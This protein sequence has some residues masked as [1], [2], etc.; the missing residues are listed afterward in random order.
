MAVEE[1]EVVAVI[2]FTGPQIKLDHWLDTDAVLVE[3]KS[4][5][6]IYGELDP[7]VQLGQKVRAGDSLGSVK[8]VLRHDKGRPTSMLHL[9]LHT[10]GTRKWYEGFKEEGVLETLMDPTSHLLKITCP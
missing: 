1:G 7:S 3:G 8:R 5:V 4:G 9:E 10:H 6:I 2:P